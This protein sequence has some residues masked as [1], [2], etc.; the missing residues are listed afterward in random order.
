MSSSKYFAEF[1]LTLPSSRAVFRFSPFDQRR[2][3]PPLPAEDERNERL[4]R[5][6]RRV[7]FW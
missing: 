6:A 5:P 3:H 4:P 2:N 7:F 1:F